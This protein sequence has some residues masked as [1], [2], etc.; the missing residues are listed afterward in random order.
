MISITRFNNELL[1]EEFNIADKIRKLKKK[2]EHRLVEIEKK[3]ADNNIDVRKIKETARKTARQIKNPLDFRK[4]VNRFVS[5]LYEKKYSTNPEL[6]ETAKVILSIALFAVVL[7]INTTFY[8]IFLNSGIDNNIAM[9]IAGIFVA[10]IVEETA[11]V[12]SIKMGATGTYFV[13]FNIGEFCVW[14]KNYMD[15]GISIGPVQI[16]SRLIPMIMHGVT[17][18]IHYNAD[19]EGKTGSGFVLGTLLHMCWNFLASLPHF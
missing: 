12:I 14:M 18:M 6:D 16:I 2:I 5:D 13:L 3:L 17:T 9:S 7:F 15:M 10:P 8:F 1:Y 11:K 4:H 19:K